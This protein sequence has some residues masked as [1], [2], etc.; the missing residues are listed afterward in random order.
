MDINPSSV[1]ACRAREITLNILHLL[2]LIAGNAFCAFRAHQKGYNP[3]IWFFTPTLFGLMVM[4][5]L[6]FTTRKSDSHYGDEVVVKRGNHIG[7]ALALFFVFLIIGMLI[8][9]RPIG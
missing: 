5:S 1:V 6:P 7:M 9:N 2:V 8:R 4:A 3:V